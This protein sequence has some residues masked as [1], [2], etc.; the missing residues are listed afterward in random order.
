M[1]PSTEGMKELHKHKRTQELPESYLLCSEC[2]GTWVEAKH[3]QCHECPHDTA[4]SDFHLC[5]TCALD[6]RR[7]QHCGQRMHIRITSC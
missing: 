7:C 1:H 5:L 4:S 6:Q 2:D 3:G